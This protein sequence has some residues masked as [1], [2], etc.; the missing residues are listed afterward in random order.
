[1]GDCGPTVHVRRTGTAA[2]K[3]LEKILGNRLL[4]VLS[5]PPLGSMDNCWEVVLSEKG[6]RVPTDRTDKRGSRVLC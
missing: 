2:A 5:V 6:P 4:A 3:K 1:M